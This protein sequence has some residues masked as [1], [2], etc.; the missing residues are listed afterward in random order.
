MLQ[1]ASQISV[2]LADNACLVSLAVP[3]HQVGCASVAAHCKQ[4]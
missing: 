3:T 1:I 4:V 2:Y